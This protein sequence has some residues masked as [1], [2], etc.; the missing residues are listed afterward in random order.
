MIAEPPIRRLFV[1][2]AVHQDGS[3][4]M[5]AVRG[6]DVDNMPAWFPLVTAKE[7]N[8]LSQ[9]ELAEAT[10]STMNATAKLVRFVIEETVH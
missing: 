5:M 7:A 4:G 9:R 1:W 2:I 3:E 6:I 8:A 10:A